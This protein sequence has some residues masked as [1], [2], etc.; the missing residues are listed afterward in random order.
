MSASTGT[1]SNTNIY[2]ALERRNKWVHRLRIGVPIFGVLVLIALLGQLIAANIA[3]QFLPQGVRIDRDNVVVDAPSYSGVM[4]DGTQYTVTSEIAE[5]AINASDTIFLS[6]ARIDLLRPSG[7]EVVGE[8]AKAR[9][10]FSAQQVNID[11]V[12]DVAESGGAIARLHNSVFDWL[13]Q[14]LDTSDSV[15]ITFAD[16][17]VL[18]SK[19]L[20]Y[21]AE[22]Q[23]WD[24]RQVKLVVPGEPN[25]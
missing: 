12:M 7:Q 13:A 11:G 14:T 4:Q 19:T 15:H 21:E 8:A 18:T 1:N 23:E 17:A 3:S 22:T 9:F 6:D 2:A 10:S 24:F 20:H 5:A 16:G 25:Q